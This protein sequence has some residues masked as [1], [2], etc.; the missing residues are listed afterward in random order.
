[1]DEKEEL[2]W[3]LAYCAAIIRDQ[4]YV[5]EVADRAV[6]DFRNAEVFCP[7]HPPEQWEDEDAPF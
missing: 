1:M 4:G 7:N 2:M 6:E 3:M 5:K